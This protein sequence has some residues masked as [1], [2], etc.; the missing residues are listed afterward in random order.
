MKDKYLNHAVEIWDIVHQAIQRAGEKGDF[1]VWKIQR[2]L[3]DADGSNKVRI[4]IARILEE[5]ERN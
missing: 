3:I 5:R 1:D 4:E 2:D